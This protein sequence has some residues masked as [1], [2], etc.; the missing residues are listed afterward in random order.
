MYMNHFADVVSD[1]AMLMF[2]DE[3]ARNKK[4]PP[5]KWAGHCV[6]GNVFNSSALS[7]D[8]AFLFYLS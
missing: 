1:P 8:S 5:K 2:V 4:I 7:K 6:E 3:A